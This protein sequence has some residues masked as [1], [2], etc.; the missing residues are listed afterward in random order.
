V[1]FCKLVLAATAVIFVV[2]CEAGNDANKASGSE[3]TTS[4]STAVKSFHN[5][6]CYP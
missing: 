6:D 5:L 1:L 4:P 3:E 2:G